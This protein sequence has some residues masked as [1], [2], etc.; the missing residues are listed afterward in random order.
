MFYQEFSKWLNDQNFKEIY[1]KRNRLI[2]FQKLEY[3]RIIYLL[4]DN[5]KFKLIF[6][7]IKVSPFSKKL[8]LLLI[9]FLPIFL[10]NFKLKYF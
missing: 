6:D 9:Y 5:K 7:I 10:I 4:L 8:K 3:L 2:L 1:F